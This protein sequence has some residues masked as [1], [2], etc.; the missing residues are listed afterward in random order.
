[1][2]RYPRHPADCQWPDTPGRH[3]RQ[4]QEAF[5]IVHAACLKPLESSGFPRYGKGEDKLV[6]WRI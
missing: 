1:M 2:E 4:E 3:G 6:L 5:C